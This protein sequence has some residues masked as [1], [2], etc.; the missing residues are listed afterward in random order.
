MHLC[1]H[2]LEH[3]PKG[4]PVRPLRI[5]HKVLSVAFGGECV[6]GAPWPDA[7]LNWKGGLVNV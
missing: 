5:N 2:Y 4:A 3:F 6:L 7:P 1:E